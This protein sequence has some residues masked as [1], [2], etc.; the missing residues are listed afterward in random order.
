MPG[1]NG[2]KHLLCG[3]GTGGVRLHGIA[4][5]DDFLAQP[6]LNRGVTL[7]PGPQSGSHNLA[8]GGVASGCNKA[9]D[10]TS[11]TTSSLAV[12]QVTTIGR[13]WVTAEATCRINR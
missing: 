9:I 3:N 11:L 2:G 13:F 7:L 6:L 1:A 5:A 10:V 8:G 4:D 12:F